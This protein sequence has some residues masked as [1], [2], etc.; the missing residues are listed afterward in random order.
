MRLAHASGVLLAAL[1][2]TLA[3]G[4]AGCGRGEDKAGPSARKAAAKGGTTKAHS[5]SEW[6]CAEHGVPE[7]LC[8]L[9]SDALMAKAKKEGDWCEHDRARS[10]CFA[11]TPGAR[12][13][14]ARMYRE[15]YGKEPPPPTEQEGSGKAN[16]GA[17]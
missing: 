16:K 9:C 13:H 2:A 7:H 3:L 11:C 5:H 14:Y 1:A 12:A 6:W 15:R 4:G 10:Q 17:K 8:I